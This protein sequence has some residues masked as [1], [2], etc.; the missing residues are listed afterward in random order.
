MSTCR[1]ALVASFCLLI[2]TGLVFAQGDSDEAGTR[3][4]GIEHGGRFFGFTPAHLKGKQG[5]RLSRRTVVAA[6]ASDDADS[7]ATVTTVSYGEHIVGDPPLPP[8]FEGEVIDLSEDVKGG[9]LWIDNSSCYW[10]NAEYLLMWTKGMST[11]PLVTTS[12][13]GTPQAQAG[14]LGQPG[15]TILFGNRDMTDGSRSGVRLSLGRWLDPAHCSGIEASYMALGTETDSFNAGLNQFNILARPF[16]DT[17]GRCGRFSV[18][19]V[20]R[21]RARDDECGCQHTVSVVRDPVS[22]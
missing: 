4:P 5:Q 21:H 16:F 7:S 20:P 10:M 3:T 2:S 22:S 1:L 17:V 14:V 9:K 11:P 8:G 15:T 12:T 18:D 13:A 6:D 19:R